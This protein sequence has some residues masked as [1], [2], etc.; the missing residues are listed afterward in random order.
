M[1]QLCKTNIVQLKILH[2]SIQFSYSYAQ[3]KKATETQ[4]EKSH[5]H[6]KLEQPDNRKSFIQNRKRVSQAFKRKENRPNREWGGV[7][8]ILGEKRINALNEQV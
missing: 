1:K 2:G 4:K 6:T 3:K 8:N 5:K 7:N